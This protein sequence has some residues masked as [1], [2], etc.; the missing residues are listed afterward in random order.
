MEDAVETI[1]VDAMARMPEASGPSIF[2][3]GEH[4]CRPRDPRY[5]PPLTKSEHVR[6]VGEV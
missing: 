2:P 3:R 6:L 5:G 1:D 4:S